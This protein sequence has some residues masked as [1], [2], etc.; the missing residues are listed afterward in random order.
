M[1]PGPKKAST[2]YKGPTK[3]EASKRAR[4]EATENV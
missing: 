3:S 2:T 1:E 4:Y